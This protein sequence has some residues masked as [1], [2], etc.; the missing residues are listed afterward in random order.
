MHT[1]NSSKT[2]IDRWNEKYR[3]GNPAGTSVDAVPIEPKGEVELVQWLSVNRARDG[4]KDNRGLALD[5]ACGRGANALYLATEG[6]DVVAMDGAV[7]GLKYCESSA[8]HR[9]LPVYTAAVDLTN[10]VLPRQAF[11][12]ICVVRYLQRS[13]VPELKSALVPGG[14]IFMKTFNQRF[15]RQKPKFNPDYVLREGE[16]EGWFEDFEIIAATPQNIAHAT[17]EIEEC[18]SSYIIAQK[19]PRLHP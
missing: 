11:N 2:D 7:E 10:T 3:R 8:V 15:L 13:L 19:P 14:V 17:S 6:Y 16:L 12:L 18:T 1:G 4:T 9:D 5:V